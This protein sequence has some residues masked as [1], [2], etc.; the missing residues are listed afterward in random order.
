[1]ALGQDRLDKL[2]Q[3]EKMYTQHGQNC[4]IKGQTEGLI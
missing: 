4:H 3:T 2:E 1:M